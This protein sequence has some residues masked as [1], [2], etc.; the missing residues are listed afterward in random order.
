[1]MQKEIHFSPLQVKNIPHNEMK[2]CVLILELDAAANSSH[3]LL[4]I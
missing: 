2:N 1:M 3:T 4:K